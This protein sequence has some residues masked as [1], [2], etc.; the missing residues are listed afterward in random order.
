MATDDVRAH[1]LDSLLARVKELEAANMKNGAYRIAAE[2]ERDH[3]AALVAKVREALSQRMNVGNTET[4]HVIAETVGY[5]L[6]RGL[7]PDEVAAW[8]DRAMGAEHNEGMVLSDLAAA[9]AHETTLRD[10]LNDAIQVIEWCG[11]N[12]KTPTYSYGEA[13]PNG[14]KPELGATFNTPREFAAYWPDRL[15]AAVEGGET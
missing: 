8:R 5:Y 15:R 4:L 6:A 11:L 10:A 12:D 2:K 13:R 9:V 3:Q 14:D 7:D 1:A